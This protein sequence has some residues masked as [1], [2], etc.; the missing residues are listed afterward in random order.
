MKYKKSIFMLLVLVGIFLIY[1]LNTNNKINY[2]ALGDSF[3]AGQNPYGEIGY[4]Y[5]DYIKDY[6]KKENILN[7]YT[8]EF[9]YSE[10]RINDLTNKIRK[11]EKVKIQNKDVSIQNAIE[12]ADI[13]TISIGANDLFEKTGLKDMSYNLENID[14]FYEYLD[15]MKKDLDELLKLIRKYNNNQIILIG[16]YNPL[17]TISSKYTRELEPIFLKINEIYSNISKNNNCEYIDIYEIFKENP[18][19]LPNPTDIHPNI[20]GYEVISSQIINI[21]KKSRIN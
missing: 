13:I 7:N 16:T 4:G 2:L 14:K 8:K 12:K 20:E 11:N 17:S 1:K 21:L 5:T 6:L 18:E 10:D 9:T 19:Y 3:A 15:D